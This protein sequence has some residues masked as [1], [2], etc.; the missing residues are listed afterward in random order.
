MC[1]ALSYFF[2][3]I[4]YFCILIYIASFSQIHKAYRLNDLLSQ[5]LY[6]KDNNLLAYNTNDKGLYYF[7]TDIKDVSKLYLKM[8][9][10][11]EDKRFNYHL[12]V[13]PLAIVR[14][15][16]QNINAHKIKSG[17]STIAMQTAKMLYQNKRSYKA[18]IKE[19]ILAS[20]LTI[21]Y[22]HDR[23]M[24]MYLSMLP[25][26]SSINSTKAASFFL[27]KK[28]PN[29]L[30]TLESALLVAIPKNPRLI[31]N[32]Y[33][34]NR[35]RTLFYKNLVL[36]SALV[37]KVID[38]KSYKENLQKNIDI[39]SCN[40]YDFKKCL[41]KQDAYYLGLYAF[42][43]TKEKEIKS[44]IDKRVQNTLI[45]HSKVIN[46]SDINKNLGIVVISNTNKLVG[47]VGGIQDEAFFVDINQ[48]RRTSARS[49]DPFIYTYAL[50]NN[51]ITNNDLE[52]SSRFQSY[53]LK[54]LD[55]TKIRSYKSVEPS[56]N[57]SLNT[58][59]KSLLQ[60]IKTKRFLSFIN[61]DHENVIC[62]DYSLAL[63]LGSCSSRL[64]DLTNLYTVFNHDGLLNTLKLFYTKNNKIFLKTG[65][66]ATY[67]TKKDNVKTINNLL[68]YTNKDLSMYTS[69][70]YN[71]QDI[72]SFAFNN[73]YTIGIRAIKIDES[74]Y[75]NKEKNYIN[76]FL[77][78][79]LKDLNRVNNKIERD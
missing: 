59:A 41:Y 79:V 23:V 9:I 54:D 70:S 56:L 74:S 61:K 77:L 44:F 53:K 26:G 49:L 34:E 17:A 21:Y 48:S 46:K 33:K 2:K 11:S 68:M 6:D 30:N 12:G 38:E 36:K 40:A 66:Y 10:A 28:A 27:F 13:D 60:K 50:N 65:R 32:I 69:A 15:F 18:K 43:N 1:K 20:A 7:K 71:N 4:F 64:L 57:R 58:E 72:L 75:S 63:A 19:A 29:K 5:S 8:L 14:A 78:S 55:S 3:F 35:K 47:Y 25:F 39:I 62:R 22:G 76:N 52:L 67:F 42:A 37:N 31:S 51:I 24:S 73:N 45:K 16:Y